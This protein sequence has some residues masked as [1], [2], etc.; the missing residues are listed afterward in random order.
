MHRFQ[1]THWDRIHFT[2][3]I[4]IKYIEAYRL[5]STLRFES[6]SHKFKTAHWGM[7]CYAMFIGIKYIGAYRLSS[8]LLPKCKN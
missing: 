3:I 6:D 5:S 7:I 8:I 1:A 2:M 4:G